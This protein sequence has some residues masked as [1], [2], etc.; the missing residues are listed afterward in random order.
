M[1]EQ[2][3]DVLK[4]LIGQMVEDRDINSVLGKTLRV[5]G[6]AEVFEPICNLLSDPF[7]GADDRAKPGRP[8]K[9]LA[10]KLPRSTPSSALNRPDSG[11]SLVV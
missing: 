9:S 11:I 5:V 8:L 1:P 2:D 6:H 7:P 4:I 3:T 10:D